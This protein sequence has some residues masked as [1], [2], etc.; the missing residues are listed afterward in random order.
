MLALAVLA[1]ILLLY[2]HGVLFFRRKA[3]ITGSS[4]TTNGTD[5]QITDLGIV[6]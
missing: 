5:V 4:F 1:S 2:Q 3:K 6:D